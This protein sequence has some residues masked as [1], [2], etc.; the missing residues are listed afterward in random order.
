MFRT[1]PDHF[2]SL[3]DERVAE[4]LKSMIKNWAKNDG[5][6]RDVTSP[7]SLFFSVKALNN[8]SIALEMLEGRFEWNED[9]KADIARWLK[10]RALEMYPADTNKSP[11]SDLCPKKIRSDF[12]NHYEAC[13]KRDPPSS[14]PLE[15]WHLD[16]RSRIY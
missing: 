11:S 14:S 13:K 6:R 2:R 8:V 12:K 7:L 16:R 4:Q 15:N 5:L 10:R 3:S 9:E 1:L